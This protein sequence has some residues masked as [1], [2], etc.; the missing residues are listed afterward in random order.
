MTAHP[1]FLVLRAKLGEVGKA[2]A[3]MNEVHDHQVRLEKDHPAQYSR[4]VH[5][6][7]LATNLQGIYTQSEAIL[8]SLLQEIDAYVPTADSWHRDLLLQAS[9]ATADLPAIISTKTPDVAIAQA[10]V[11]AFAAE[12]EQFLED[13]DDTE[14]H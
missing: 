7:S 13:F 14:S 2:M 1:A 12:V 10:T 9:I 11:P 6:E 4:D 8:K 5:V 3:H